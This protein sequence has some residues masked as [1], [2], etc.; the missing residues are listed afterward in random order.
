MGREFGQVEAR[1]LGCQGYRG[2][3]DLTVAAFKLG[4]H[5]KRGSTLCLANA[6]PL[7]TRAKSKKN[8]PAHET[9]G[10]GNRPAQDRP[11]FGT[12]Q[13]GLPERAAGLARSSGVSTS[14]ARPPGTAIERESRRQAEAL[15]HAAETNG[16]L[17]Q[18][19]QLAALGPVLSQG[20]E[21]QVHAALDGARVVKVTLGG[22]HGYSIMQYRQGHYIGLRPS[23]P[24]EYFERLALQNLL[25]GDGQRYEGILRDRR[26]EV[27][28]ITSQSMVMGER[29]TAAEIARCMGEMGFDPV[30]G[31]EATAFYRVA[32]NVAVFD[33]HTGNFIKTAWGL[34]PIDVVIRYPED[35]LLELQEPGLGGMSL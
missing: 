10:S 29:P 34:V 13:T 32:D 11:A 7:D 21:H 12:N 30:A 3:Y 2:S 28:L 31:Q 9:P 25:F 24:A 19:S 6:R 14:R 23:T 5:W 22:R 26:G 33:A 17:I 27:R 1:V 15:A 35:W 16:Q 20:T 4:I 8:E 18:L